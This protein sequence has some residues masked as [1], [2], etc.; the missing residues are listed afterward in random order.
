[1]KKHKTGQNHQKGPDKN[2]FVNLTSLNNMG[3]EC[4]SRM[5]Q[6]LKKNKP[7]F[8]EVYLT[9]VYICVMI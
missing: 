2:P 5:D 9:N 6:E 1:M 3:S 8:I 7:S 4:E